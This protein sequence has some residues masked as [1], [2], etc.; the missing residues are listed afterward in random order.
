MRGLK[1]IALWLVAVISFAYL[2]AQNINPHETYVMHPMAYYF[3]ISIVAA[4]ITPLID[5]R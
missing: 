3:L 4:L 5:K 2:G 1:Y